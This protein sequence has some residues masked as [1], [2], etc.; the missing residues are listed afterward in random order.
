MPSIETVAQWLSNHGLA[1]T[2]AMTAIAFAAEAFA[3]RESASD[4]RRH[5]AITWRTNLLLFAATMAISWTIAPWLSPLLSAWLSGRDGALS[6]IDAPFAL[7]VVMGFLLLDL[8]SYAIHRVLHRVG[9]LWRLH[10]VHHCD[11]A[12][13]AST[14]F[15]QHPLSTIVTLALQLPLLWVA[16]IP[17]VSWVLYA[18]LSAAIELW[19]HADITPPPWVEYALGGWLVTP[20]VHRLHHHP[21]RA[22]HDNNYGAA[23]CVW[24]H[25][26]RTYR[27]PHASRREPT[28]V[29]GYPASAAL[30]IRACLLAPFTASPVASSNAASLIHTR[31]RA[32]K[33]AKQPAVQHRKTS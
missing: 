11:I 21:D 8:G 30:S 25:L 31:K 28:G 13:N 7:R 9:W 16:G 3:Q 6:L 1:L 14:H 4:Q 20:G 18:T 22:V 15:R 10:Q 17:G 27:K 2:L 26:F 5:W 12:M 23:F 24:D 19:H 33:Y 32:S 29:A